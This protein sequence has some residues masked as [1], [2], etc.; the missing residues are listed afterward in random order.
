MQVVD[1]SVVLLS[2]VLAEASTLGNPNV[3]SQQRCNVSGEYTL[4]REGE[5]MRLRATK[6]SDDRNDIVPRA[7][8][9]NWFF[10]SCQ[11]R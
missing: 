6:T 8:L 5:G 7:E 9:A 3:H 11:F 1:G 2:V 4:K 10:E